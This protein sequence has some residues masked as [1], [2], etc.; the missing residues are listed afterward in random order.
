ML[1]A[2][3]KITND[4]RVADA[5]A[6][7]KAEADAKAAAKA[8][9]ERLF[10]VGYKAGVKLIAGLPQMLAESAAA[11]ND[12]YTTWVA[13]N[14]P[15]EPQTLGALKAVNE[16]MPALNVNWELFTYYTQTYS[17]NYEGECTG[18]D[19]GYNRVTLG[20]WWGPK[21]AWRKHNEPEYYSSRFR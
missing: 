9:K 6:K 3:A 17:Y 12:H 4:K 15:G 2:L 11:G 7:A 13:Y 1:E 14:E 21:P 18:P 10:E 20:V 8:E 5:V 16:L 19:G